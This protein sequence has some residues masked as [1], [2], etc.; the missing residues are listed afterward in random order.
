MQVM[1]PV[2]FSLVKDTFHRIR[3]PIPFPRR[4]R[5]PLPR[6]IAGYDGGRFSIEEKP[7]DKPHRFRFFLNDLRQ[8]ILALFMPQEPPIEQAHLSV[9][10]PLPLPPGHILGNGA[11]LLLRQRGHDV[12]IFFSF[13]VSFLSSGEFKT[14][15]INRTLSV[16]CEI[17]FCADS[18]LGYQSVRRYPQFSAL[19]SYRSY[20]S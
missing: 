13:S 14:Q 11:V 19:S 12:L 18:I 7:V 4:G 5:N 16:N 6:Q 1:P 3:A 10:K 20:S 2:T 15:M 17:I 8:I 9:H